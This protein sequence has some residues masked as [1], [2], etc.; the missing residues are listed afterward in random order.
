MPTVVRKKKAKVPPVRAVDL[1]GVCAEL[2]ALQRQRTA[3]IVVAVPVGA[4]RT[5]REFQAVADEVVCAEAPE[6]FGAVGE[7]YDDFSQT[8]DREVCDLLAQA[9]QGDPHARGIR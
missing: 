3:R 4:A 6:T 5:C 8:G 9:E 2:Q 7:W 1:P